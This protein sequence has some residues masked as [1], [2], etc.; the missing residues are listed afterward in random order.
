MGNS[1]ALLDSSVPCEMKRVR[2]TRFRLVVLAVLAAF[3]AVAGTFVMR[4]RNVGDL[5]NVGDPFDVARAQ[6]PVLVPDDLNAYVSYSLARQLRIRAP[7]A[8]SRVKLATLTWAD[9]GAIGHDYL[10]QNR[11]ALLAWRAGT[12]RPDALYHQPGKLRFDTILPLVDDLRELA[13]L[14]G[15]E[16]S[17][18]EEQGAMS[19]AWSWY[20]SILRSSRHVGMRGLLLERAAGAVIHEKTARRIVRWA[21]DPRVD[22]ALLRRALAEALAAD[23]MTPPLSENM[24]LEYLICMRDLNELRYMTGEIPLPGGRLGLLERAVTSK[25]VRDELQRARLRVINDVMRSRRV[26]R[27]L[28]ANWLAQV[29][30]PAAQRAPIAIPLPVVIYGADPSAPPAARAIAPE[31]LDAAIRKTLFAAQY[32]RPDY[33]SNLGGTPWAGGAWEGSGTLA[34]EPRRRAVLIV[35]LAAELYRREH[36]KPPANAGTLIGAYLEEL[37]AEIARDELIPDGID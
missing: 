31:E 24:K 21:A 28:Y 35:K 2:L 5:P 6:R 20:R 18:V 4:L 19:E 16:G 9:A 12:E 30:K 3:V 10:E 15:L 7:A 34:R 26:L 23:A 11:P 27:L 37:P 8:L 29:D 22:A 14:A 1:T 25:I 36:G 17:R 33:W 32:L 13:W